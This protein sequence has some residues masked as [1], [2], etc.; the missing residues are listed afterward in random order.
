MSIA[1]T[2]SHN[3]SQENYAS[4]AFAGDARF[5]KIQDLYTFRNEAAIRKFLSKNAALMNV[6]IEAYPH[7]VRYFGDQSRIVLERV[8]D[9]EIQDADQLVAYVMTS[10]SVDEAL[11]RLNRLDEEWFLEQFDRVDGLLNFNLEFVNA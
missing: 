2:T 7:V 1:T 8:K 11:E 6:L 9:P 3:I 10:L 4:L 5:R